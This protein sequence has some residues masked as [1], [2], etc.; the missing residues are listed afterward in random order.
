VRKMEPA[1]GGTVLLSL[2]LRSQ[3]RNAENS[4]GQYRTGAICLGIILT[5]RL[6]FSRAL[7][8]RTIFVS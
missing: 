1:F 7:S 2:S 8:F 3:D 4:S 6:L 5:L